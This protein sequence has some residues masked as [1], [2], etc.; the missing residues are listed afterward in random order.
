VKYWIDLEYIPQLLDPISLAI[1]AEDGREYLAQFIEAK[2]Q[3]ADEFVQSEVIP[4]LSRC[5]HERYWQ[6]LQHEK[7][8]HSTGRCANDCPWDFAPRVASVLRD[9]CDPVRYGPPQFWTDCGAFDY[10]LV[11][12]LFGNFS[13]WPAGWPFYFNDLQQWADQLAVPLPEQPGGQ[14]QALADARHNQ[15]CWDFLHFYENRTRMIRPP[16]TLQI[17]YR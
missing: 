6:S 15:V 7:E 4:Q 9:F 12:Q 3:W 1:V 16:S 8:S 14:H 2:W 13:D 10:V 11:S 17:G 5:T